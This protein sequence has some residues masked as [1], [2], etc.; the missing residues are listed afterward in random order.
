[1]QSLQVGCAGWY[2]VKAH[3]LERG[4]LVTVRKSAL[5]RL[6]AQ[7]HMCQE[8]ARTAVKDQLHVTKLH[9]LNVVLLPNPPKAINP[10][11]DEGKATLIMSELSLNLV[12][13]GAVYIDTILR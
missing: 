5:S 2:S 4:G 3:L 10:H 9:S 8:Y 1:M 13:V 11:H 7:A 12:F 6:Q